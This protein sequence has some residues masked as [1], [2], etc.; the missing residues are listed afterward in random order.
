M[1]GDTR[2]LDYG[3][4]EVYNGKFTDALNEFA[5]LPEMAG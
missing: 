3:S 2:S 5:I 1:K 4:Y